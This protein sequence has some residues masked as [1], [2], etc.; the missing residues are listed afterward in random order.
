MWIVTGT[1]AFLPGDFT[2]AVAL[3]VVPAPCAPSATPVRTTAAAPAIQIRFTFIVMSSLA[4]WPK[5]Y[6][7][8]PA[9]IYADSA[10]G[11]SGSTNAAVMTTKGM[12]RMGLTRPRRAGAAYCQECGAYQE[13]EWALS[14][15]QDPS[16]IHVSSSGTRRAPSMGSLS[17]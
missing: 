13:K 10:P 8:L 16:G 14:V 4:L 11:T 7:S 6:P 12:R 17:C 1:D 2:V 15:V 9:A 5:T 3:K